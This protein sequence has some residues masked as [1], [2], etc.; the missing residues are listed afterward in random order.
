LTINCLCYLLLEDFADGPWETEEQ[1]EFYLDRYPFLGYA[2]DFWGQHAKP[3]EGDSDVQAKLASFFASRSAMAV[4]N[5]VRQYALGRLWEYWSPAE[6]LS[7]T[8][9]HFAA[10]HGLT[11]TMRQLLD[12]DVFDVNVMTG[13]GA[14]PIINAAANGHVDVVRTLLEKGA[15]PYLRNW[16]GDAL[17]CAAEG[18]QAGSVRELVRWGM[19]PNGPGDPTRNYIDCTL[20]GDAASSFEA[21]VQLGVDLNVKKSCFWTDVEV[22]QCNSPLIFFAACS[23]GCEKIVK[24]M[25]DRGWANFNLISFQGRT[26]LHWAARGRCLAVVQK[27]VD[28]GADI[29]A[30]D[31]DGVSALELMRH[32]FGASTLS[33]VLGID[34]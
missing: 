33:S 10:R 17:H 16:Y 8:P 26:G 28:A 30:V 32:A 1:V 29:H 31:D 14:T 34:I 7:F 23:L 21:L 13:Q 6:G 3:S 11:Q 25:V 5:Q 22:A 27:L 4:A 19:N 18:N 12:Q 15:N 20:G 24:L 2:A 9:V